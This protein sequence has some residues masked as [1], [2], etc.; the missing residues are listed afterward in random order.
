MFEI[1]VYLF[2]RYIHENCDDY[3]DPTSISHELEEAGFSEKDIV[4]A[5]LWLDGLAKHRETS[6]HLN[7]S[8]IPGLRV[9]SSEEQRKLD[10]ETMGF[11][12]FL[13]QS[14][15]I[16]LKMRELILDRAMAIEAPVVA[17]D[18]VKWIALILL[19]CQSDEKHDLQWL[20]NL[21]LTE[22]SSELTLH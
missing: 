22:H 4:N 20:E 10:S 16:N 7:E 17:L 11:L 1:I 19:F 12:M 2:E 3:T 18:E 14:N 8:L 6:E 13:E 15:I 21:I 5:F 9:Y